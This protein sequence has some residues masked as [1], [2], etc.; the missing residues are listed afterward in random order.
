MYTA[1]AAAIPAEVAHAAARAPVVARHAALH[2]A[3]C[4]SINGQNGDSLSTN[5]PSA[6]LPGYS[7]AIQPAKRPARAS[8][9]I[10]V[11]QPATPTAAV[12]NTALSNRA[13]ATG[14]SWPYKRNS[15]D[16]TTG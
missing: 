1:A 4:A 11:H 6:T 16:S 12:P 7:A 3:K 13:A 14:G 10:V 5:T 8:K 2:A 9:S 15:L